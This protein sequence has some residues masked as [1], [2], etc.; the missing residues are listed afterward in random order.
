MPNE[1]VDYSSL[2]DP[3]ISVVQTIPGLVA[4]IF[5]AMLFIL[6]VSKVHRYIMYLLD[7]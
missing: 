5:T 3:S 2:V 1:T 4:S 7:R 6:I